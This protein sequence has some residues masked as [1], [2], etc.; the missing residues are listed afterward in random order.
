M[1]QKRILEVNVVNEVTK[2]LKLKENC[3]K[4]LPDQKSPVGMTRKLPK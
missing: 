2:E 1:G 3:N 4:P